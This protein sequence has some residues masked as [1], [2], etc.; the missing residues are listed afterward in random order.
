MRQNKNSANW[1][2]TKNVKQK[3]YCLDMVHVD[4]TTSVEEYKLWLRLKIHML[5]D[6]ISEE[7]NNIKPTS[8]SRKFTDNHSLQAFF[9]TKKNKTHKMQLHTFS[10]SPSG[11]VVASLF[12]V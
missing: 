9:F 8:N 2:I 11:A 10:L 5:S 4:N 3:Q 6:V 1:V 7:N 12:G